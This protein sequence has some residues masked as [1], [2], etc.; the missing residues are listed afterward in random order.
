MNYPYIIRCQDF[1]PW[2]FFPPGLSSPGHNSP[3]PA[4]L[5]FKVLLYLPI[6]NAMS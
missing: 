2:S 3:L 5:A 6:V 1:L 4:N